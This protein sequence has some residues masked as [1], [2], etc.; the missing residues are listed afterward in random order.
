MR[1]HN[2]EEVLNDAM[3]STKLNDARYLATYICAM[4][5]YMSAVALG[6]INWQP[7]ATISPCS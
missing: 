1:Q 5:R 7:V 4:T 2:Y 6:G 3:Q